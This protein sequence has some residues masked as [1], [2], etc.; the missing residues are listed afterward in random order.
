MVRQTRDIII[1]QG[2]TEIYIF[3]KI[4]FVHK[5][6]L[7]KSEV[8]RISPFSSFRLELM[9]MIHFNV[10]KTTHLQTVT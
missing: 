1:F 2:D 6:I 9:M 8:I 4:L 7:Q 5:F 3:Q 10:H